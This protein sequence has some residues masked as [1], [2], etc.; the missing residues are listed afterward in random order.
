[1]RAPPTRQHT[2]QGSHRKQQL[3]DAAARLFAERGYTAT[4]VADV[5]HAAGAAKG[6]FYWYFA[7]KDDLLAELVASMR[8]RLRRAQRAGIDPGADPLTQLRRGAE[9]SVRF[10]V[11][12]ASYFTLLDVAH[13]DASHA[14]LVRNGD[15]VHMAD[16]V[17]L[18]AAAQAA[19]QVPADVD[20]RLLALCVNGTVAQLA[21]FHR[22]GRVSLDVDEL[23][24]FA[25][26]WV[27]RALAGQIPLEPVAP[28]ATVPAATATAVP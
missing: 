15:R 11:V 18:V 2:D 1:M 3:L 12:H 25:G 13:R 23:A 27:A 8:L 24:R 4:R 14:D 19:G 28:A 5:C 6:L 22:T 10:M 21:H 20:A 7:S 17:A 16:T 26:T 9:A